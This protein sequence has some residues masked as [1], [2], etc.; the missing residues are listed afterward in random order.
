MSTCFGRH[1]LYN[2]LYLICS[3]HLYTWS[4]EQHSFAQPITLQTAAY[5]IQL[6]IPF[7]FV[8]LYWM[9]YYFSH[10]SLVTFPYHQT[11]I[12]VRRGRHHRFPHLPLPILKEKLLNR[13]TNSFRIYIYGT[14]FPHAAYNLTKQYNMAGPWTF[15]ARAI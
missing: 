5:C 6:S 4:E 9:I 3:T 11:S 7:I 10:F 12:H 13:T 2:P 1:S 14:C 15:L 8:S